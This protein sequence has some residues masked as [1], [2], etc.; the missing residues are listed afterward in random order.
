M[1]R[2]VATPRAR[3]K[4]T[5]RELDHKLLFLV[6]IGI[7][8]A[9]GFVAGAWQHFAATDYSYRRERLLEYKNKLAIERR[10]LLLEHEQA[11]APQQVDQAARTKGFVVPELGQLS[12]RAATASLLSDPKPS[13]GENAREKAAPER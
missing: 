13:D 10:R 12:V 5:M 7:F 2:R 9:L 4:K 6:A 8:L 3:R 11:R 1:A